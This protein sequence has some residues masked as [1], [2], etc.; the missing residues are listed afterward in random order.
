MI[1]SAYQDM[2]VDLFFTNKTVAVMGRQ[3]NQ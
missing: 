2:Y 3:V 1:A